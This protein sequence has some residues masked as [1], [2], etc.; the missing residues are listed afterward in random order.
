MACEPPSSFE[1]ISKMSPQKPTNH[2]Q[3]SLNHP[4][5]ITQESPDAGDFKLAMAMYEKIKGAEK[6]DEELYYPM[7][8]E[9]SPSKL[10]ESILKKENL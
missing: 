1:G 2:R 3:E 5:I 4:Q 9:S 8:T 10:N 7:P 6:D